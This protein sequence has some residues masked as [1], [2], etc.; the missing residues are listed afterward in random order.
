MI[1]RKLNKDDIVQLIELYKHY[2][3]E[4]NLPCLDIN[5][6]KQIWQQVESNPCVSYFALETEDKL[7]ASCILTI[8]PSI[9]RGGVG[10]GFI[11]HVVTHINHRRKGYGEAIVTYAL[12]H[13]WNNGCTEVMLLSGSKNTRAHKMYEKIGFNRYRK[14][15]FVITNPLAP[16]TN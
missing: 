15:G 2:I 16:P 1:I 6:L 13:A 4:D 10:Y 14:T 3:S 12:N 9:I 8:T 5:I 11:E 7:I